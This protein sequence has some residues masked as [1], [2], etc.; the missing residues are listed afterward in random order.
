MNYEC[1]FTMESNLGLTTYNQRIV[2]KTAVTHRV[3]HISL[4]YKHN[5]IHSNSVDTGNKN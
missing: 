3:L 5:S 1:I 2:V 4:N